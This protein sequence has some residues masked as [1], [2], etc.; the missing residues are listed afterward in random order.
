LSV[1]GFTTRFTVKLAIRRLK[2]GG[3]A[4][5]EGE[6]HQQISKPAKGVYEL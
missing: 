2:V 4:F 3:G 5:F 1:L 6:L